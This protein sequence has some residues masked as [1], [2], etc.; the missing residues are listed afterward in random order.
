MLVRVQ[1]GLLRGINMTIKWDCIIKYRVCDRCEHKHKMTEGMYPHKCPFGRE[2]DLRVL[3]ETK[4]E[5]EHI[6][7]I[8]GR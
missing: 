7:K 4:E 6:D 3:W 2:Q 1:P 5:K 8:M